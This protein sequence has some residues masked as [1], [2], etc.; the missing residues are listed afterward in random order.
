[1]PQ[2]KHHHDESRGMTVYAGSRAD[3][4]F[5][6][7]VF[8]LAG[9]S[10]S[11]WIGTAQSLRGACLW[12]TAALIGAVAA[13]NRISQSILSF[14]R[15]L[16]GGAVIALISMAFYQL[17]SGDDGTVLLRLGPVVISTSSL[18]LAGRMALRLLAF[19]LAAA[20]LIALQSPEQLAA[21]MARLL[22]PLRPFR[23]PVESVY[24]LVYFAFRMAPMLASETQTI[25]LA[26]RSRCGG[27]PSSLLGRIRESG[28]I[29]LPVFAA[30][31]RRADR[32]SWAL[33]AR[34]FD[35]RH[36][37]A[38]VSRLRFRTTDYLTTLLVLAGW[39]VWLIPRFR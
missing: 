24:Y 31:L 8:I 37:P 21:G 36:L 10:I 18:T 5:D 28:S 6:P 13:R 16:F 29:V 25:R 15:V 26:Q 11:V 14:R 23:I 4:N 35:V 20:T 1:M 39:A 12:F 30:G 34:G 17:A 22:K 33:A 7:R 19:I 9:I 32:L 2:A 27:E 3:A 38:A